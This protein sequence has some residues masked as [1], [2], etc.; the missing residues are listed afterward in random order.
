M[1]IIPDKQPVIINAVN[2]LRR[3]HNYLFTSGGIGPTHDDITAISIAEAMQLPCIFD[4]EA[5]K[6]LRD[7][8]H[9]RHIDYTPERRLMA[10][11]PQGA[12]P[13]ANPVSAAP[14]FS[15]ENVIVM[16][17][18]PQIFQAMVQNVLPCLKK[19][20]PVHA[21]TVFCPF[22][23]SV[24]SKPLEKIQQRYPQTSIGSYPRFENAQDKAFLVEIVIRSRDITAL[25]QAGTAVEEMIVTLRTQHEM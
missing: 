23:E 20:A 7:Y 4:Q 1:R 12:R 22:G 14:G 8:Y 3:R 5:E 2:E 15:I 10:R 18:V 17:G 21:R 11:M 25:Q 6:T 24:F 9:A 19:G 13:I 16:A